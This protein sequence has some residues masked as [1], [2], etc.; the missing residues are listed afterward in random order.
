MCEVTIPETNIGWLLVVNNHESNI[1]VIGAALLTFVKEFLAN[2]S[3]DHGL[4]LKTEPDNLSDAAT[5][6]IQQHREAPSPNNS[7]LRGF[8]RVMACS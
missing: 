8:F 6:A 7:L 4:N 1:H 5:R 3:A 2:A